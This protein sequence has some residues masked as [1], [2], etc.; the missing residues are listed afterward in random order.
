M[1]VKQL[2]ESLDKYYGIKGINIETI[3]RLMFRQ[4]YLVYAADGA[5]YIVK[6]YAYAFSL[7]KFT[8]IWE[9]YWY[10]REHGVEI[11]CPL[12]K[13]QSEE[14]HIC[15]KNRYYVVFEYIEGERPCENNYAEI[16]CCLKGYHKVAK[17]G[18]DFNYITTKQKLHDA[19]IKFSYFENAD[20]LI[21]KEILSCKSNLYRI[22]EEYT[23]GEQIIIHG[24]TILENMI[25][26]NG[27]VI[28][29]D[30][31]NMRRG[32]ALED[33]ANTILSFM[34][35]GSKE[36]K[37]HPERMDLIRKLV[38]SYCEDSVIEN[39]ESKLHYYMQVHCV[40]DLV[41]H[42]ENIKFLI[43]MPGMM[44]YLLLLVKVIMSKNIKELLQ[45]ENKK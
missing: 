32:D 22:V 33:V 19:K 25:L 28:L 1:V 39:L 38:K 37:I 16:A 6:D 29:I 11:G 41:R 9:Y 15:I 12:R 31:D 44:D 42:S 18:S 27:K 3:K 14:F 40:I 26:N 45:E 30:F 13:L 10:L 36:Y 5:R 8:K 4:N 21:K 20:Y 35:Y 2:L 34:Y 43:R 17:A 24:D 23:G 7:S